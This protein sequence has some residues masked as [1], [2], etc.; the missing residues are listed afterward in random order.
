[1]RV[2]LNDL[3]WK[4]RRS[5]TKCRE[6]RIDGAEIALLCGWHENV[7]AASAAVARM[8]AKERKQ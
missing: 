4:D 7:V 5:V 6:C 8:V 2:R 1:M 3:Q